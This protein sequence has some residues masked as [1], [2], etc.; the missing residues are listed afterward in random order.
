MTIEDIRTRLVDR[1]DE[2]L[3]P[4]TVRTRR[5][6]HRVGTDALVP[7][8]VEVRM[9]GLLGQL[10][11]GNPSSTAGR[12]SSSGGSRPPGSL[13]AADTLL[14]I[15]RE[16]RPLAAQL[17]ALRVQAA[18]DG[19][20]LVA[21]PRRLIDAVRIIRGFVPDLD[22]AWLHSVD[23]TVERWWVHARVTTTWDDAPL[24]PH[25][26]CPA[27]GKVGGLRVVPEPLTMACLD[28][29]GA[30]EGSEADLAAVASDTR[31]AASAAG[32]NEQ[33]PVAR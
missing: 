7:E 25:V 1:L 3:E 10:A 12:S 4:R 21:H 8:D 5:W 9:P 28:C 33:E 26:P 6:V 2:L 23:R 19:V 11:R 31:H 16:A 17:V 27:C 18:I 32:S 24:R 15:D 29:G 30:W 13:V 20:Q 22:R 14:M